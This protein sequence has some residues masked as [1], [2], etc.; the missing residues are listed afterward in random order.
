MAPEIIHSGLLDRALQPITRV[1]DEDV[2]RA[3]APLN[4]A[5][6]GGNG[7]GVGDVRQSAQARPGM[8][9]S[10]SAT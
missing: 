5:D 4:L 7:I 3:E 8:S 2:D 9:A 1:A 10:N 6:D